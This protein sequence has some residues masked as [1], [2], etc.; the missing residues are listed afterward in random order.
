MPEYDSA[1]VKL[2]KFRKELVNA[3][4]LMQVNGIIKAIHIKRK[5]KS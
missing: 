3:L 4:E 2:E 5:Q 1:T